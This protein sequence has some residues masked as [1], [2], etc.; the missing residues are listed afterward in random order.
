MNETGAPAPFSRHGRLRKGDGMTGESEQ[1]NIQEETPETDA[2]AEAQAKAEEYLDMARRVQAEFENYR[3]RTQKENEEFRAF[4]TAGLMTELLSIV[5]DFDRALEHPDGSDVF[6]EGVR[7][8]RTNLM[9]MLEAK[10]LSEIDASGKFDPNLHEA[11]CTVDG[12]EDGMVAEVFQ[13][14]YRLGDKVLR[15][16]KVK[17]TKKS[18]PKQ[19]AAEQKN[20]QQE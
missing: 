5:D 13:K 9:K 16:A 20:E 18:A 17:V 10:G 11:L 1:G 2:L 19:D 7:G 14:G 12:D 8:I 6:V 3:R 4:A 15:Y